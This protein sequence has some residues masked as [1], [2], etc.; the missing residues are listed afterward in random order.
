MSVSRIMLHAAVWL[1]V[2]IFWLFA[3]RQFHPTTVIAVSAT[4][5]LVLVSALAVYIN[6]LFLLPRF[7]RRRLWWQYAALLAATVI[8]LDLLAVPLIQIIYDWLWRPDPLRFGFWFNVMSDGFIIVLH[9]VIAMGVVWIAKLLRR[10]TLP[11]PIK[12]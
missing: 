4:A 8:V 6:S 3:T 10:R 9:L 2:F 11:R 1:C 7:G 12:G 5:V